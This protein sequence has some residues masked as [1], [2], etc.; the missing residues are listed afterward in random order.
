MKEAGKDRRPGF[1]VVWIS[2]CQSLYRWFVRLYLPFGTA[3]S[4]LQL[5][6]KLA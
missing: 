6:L 3:R 2:H 1:A 5:V 4:Y